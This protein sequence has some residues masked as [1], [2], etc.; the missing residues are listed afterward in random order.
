MHQIEKKYSIAT[1]LDQVWEALT[2]PGT[3]TIWSGDTAQMSDKIDSDF[4][5]WDGDIYGTNTEVEKNKLLAQDW[6]GGDWDKPSKVVFKLIEHDGETELILTQNA[7]PR[8]EVDSFDAG[9][10]DY[11]LGA[12]K[13]YLE[14]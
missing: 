13:D 8:D 11:Y 2:N 12:I 7:V 5:L 4:S 14:K 3:I 1:P 9:W 6:Y 10:D